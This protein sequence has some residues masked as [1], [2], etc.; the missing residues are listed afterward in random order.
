MSIILQSDFPREFHSSS[1][2]APA[3]TVLL[4]TLALTTLFELSASLVLLVGKLTEIALDEII[5]KQLR[6]VIVDKMHYSLVSETAHQK[7]R[8]TYHRQIL[9]QLFVTEEETSQC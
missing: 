8:R 6:S 5:L 4:E 3:Y 1:T 9:V 2:E 7:G